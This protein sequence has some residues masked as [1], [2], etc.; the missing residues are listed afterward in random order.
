V[1]VS[2][3]V[4]SLDGRA[5]R[6]SHRTLCSWEGAGLEL[7][8]EL[9]QRSG[10]AVIGATP[11]GMSLLDMLPAASAAPLTCARVDVESRSWSTRMSSYAQASAGL[12]PIDLVTK[13]GAGPRTGAAWRSWG[14]CCIRQQPAC[15]RCHYA[16]GVGPRAA[17]GGCHEC[18]A[19]DPDLEVPPAAWCLR[20]AQSGWVACGLV[21]MASPRLHRDGG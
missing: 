14:C 7:A 20:H 10:R 8:V 18:V 12:A 17:L 13:A 9:P 4:V 1:R 16:D 2:W 3:M 6:R 15:P 11:P 19:M 21:R 5:R